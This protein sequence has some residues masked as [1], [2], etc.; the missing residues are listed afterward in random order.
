[1]GR[2]PPASSLLPL[3]AWRSL[4]ATLFLCTLREI[5]TGVVTDMIW[6]RRSLQTPFRARDDPSVPPKTL[7]R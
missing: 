4:R 3:A 5:A 6:K 7:Y 2:I 1:M